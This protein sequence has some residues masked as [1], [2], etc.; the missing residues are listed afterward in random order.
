VA[1]I[2]PE[3]AFTAQVLLLLLKLTARFEVAVALTVPVPPTANVGA[4]PKLM[5]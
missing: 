1:L 4:A 5:L 3:L 2:T